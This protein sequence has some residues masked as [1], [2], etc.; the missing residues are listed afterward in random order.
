MKAVLKSPPTMRAVMI[1]VLL[2]LLW[3][4][5]NWAYHAFNKPS[6]VLFPL[7]RALNKRPIE[8]W[9][10]YGSLFREH[11]TSVITAEL[12]AALAQTEGAGNPVAR[13]Y[14]RWHLSWNPF[15]WY[16]PA[17]SAVG[18]Y[19]IT[20]GTFR[21]ATRYCI[22]DHVVVEDGP[23]NDLN[24]CWFNSLYTR[25]LPSHA[26]EVTSASLDRAVAKAIGTRLDGRVT[27]RQKQD[28]AALIHLCGAGAGHAYAS[29]GFRLTPSQRCGDHDVSI[30]LAR[31]NALKFE[32][33]KPAAGDKTIRRER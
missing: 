7:D 12:L 29:R 15:E 28:L 4:G 33:S 3:L 5:V 31:V 16:Q 23:W 19:Q 11:A 1:A 8:T 14:W 21:E 20:D 18:M 9:K 25:V 10:E 2:L 17:S 27:L 30:Y 22:H 13:T 26:I 6:E 24:S 32:F